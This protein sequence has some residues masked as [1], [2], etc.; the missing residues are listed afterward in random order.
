[1]ATPLPRYWHNS[2]KFYWKWMEESTK[3]G[4]LICAS[5]ARSFSLSIRGWHQISGKDVYLGCSQ[6]ACKPDESMVDEYRKMFESRIYLCPSNL[7]GCEKLTR[8]RSLGRVTWKHLRRAI[9]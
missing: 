3:L 5:S 6:R 4:M 7:L 2:K 1:M 9:V 8:T